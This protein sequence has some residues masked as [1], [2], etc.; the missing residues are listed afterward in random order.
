MLNL[1]AFVDAAMDEDWLS[2]F[3]LEEYEEA[4]IRWGTPQSRGLDETADKVAFLRVMA[5][6]AM[7]R[8]ADALW[9]ALKDP[10]YL[11]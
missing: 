5:D 8:R 11:M 1:P 4:C 6:D 3:L 10:V 9:R 7:F 2:N